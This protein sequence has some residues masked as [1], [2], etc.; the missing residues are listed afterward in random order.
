MATSGEGRIAK[1]GDVDFRG[2]VGKH[3]AE[4]AKANQ[5]L[6]RDFA[7]QFHDDGA[8][9]YRHLRQLEG[10][11]MLMG[12][13]VRIRARKV[14]RHFNKLKDLSL[15]LSAESVKFNGQY[16]KEFLTDRSD[17]KDHRRWQGKVDL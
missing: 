7:A 17:H 16:R 10:H 1:L 3:I 11:P 12:V 9:A 4:Y 15:A 8:R 14:Q 2:K 13:D 6:A 5:Y